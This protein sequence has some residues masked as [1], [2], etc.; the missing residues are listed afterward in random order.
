[1]I[2][3]ECTLLG[4]LTRPIEIT[5]TPSG[6]P[7][8]KFSI[9]VNRKWTDQNGQTK[10][11]VAFIDCE[12]WAKSAESM[13]EWTTKGSKVLISGRLKQEQWETKEGEKRSKLK[14]VVEEWKNLNPKND[15]EGHDEGEP[16]QR[17]TQAK[18]TPPRSYKARHD[19]DL[20]P[21]EEPEFLPED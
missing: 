12:I 15:R 17:S 5:Y 11:E 10:E 9:A 1:M 3:N 6:T 19:A 20:D 8:G 21:D 14:V 2:G 18:K 16:R 4:N 7:I 13:A